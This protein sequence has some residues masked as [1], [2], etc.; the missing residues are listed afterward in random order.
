MQPLHVRWPHNSFQ[1]AK[2]GFRREVVCLHPRPRFR[3]ATFASNL[4]VVGVSGQGT[5]VTYDL[6]KFGV[7]SLE[8]RQL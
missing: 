5:R 6:G 2:G 8:V 1:Y 3:T 4:V 7:E